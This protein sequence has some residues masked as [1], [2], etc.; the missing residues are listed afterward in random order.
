MGLNE[1]EMVGDE[2]LEENSD[3]HG[4]VIEA[5]LLGLV[6]VGQR[7]PDLALEIRVRP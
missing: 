2:G 7:G 3:K 1:V 4:I 6:R 5:E